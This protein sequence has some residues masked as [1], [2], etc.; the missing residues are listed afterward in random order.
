M[1]D[2]K[3]KIL[4]FGWEF[5]PVISGGLGVACLGLCKALAPLASSLKMVIPKSTPDFKLQGIDLVGLNAF[6]KDELLEMFK[7]SNPVLDVF[8]IPFEPIFPYDNVS[9]SEFIKESF[10]DTFYNDINPFDITD[11]YGGDVVRK[12]VEFAR[13]SVQYG[14]KQD[15]DVIHAHDW[16]TFL[17]AMQ[18]K[19]LTGKPMVVHIH[20]LEYDRAG[21][22]SKN[23]VWELERR[24][25]EMADAIIPVSHY[26]GFIC[27]KYYGADGAKIYPVHNG[28]E[29]IVKTVRKSPFRQKVVIF[30]GRVTMQKGPEYFV[31]AA[32][33]VLK[34][35]NNVKFVM[36]GSGDMLRPMILKTAQYNMGDKFFFTD[37]LNKKLLNDVLAISD[38]YCM[39]SVSEPFGL[40]AAE[41]AQYGIPTII[42]KTSGVAEVLNGSLKFDFWDIN[43]FAQY[44]LAALEMDGLRQEVVTKNYESLKHITWHH[45]AEKVI[46]VYKKLI[47]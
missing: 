1:T 12:V 5:P 7:G 13:I 40:S 17:P 21:E 11:L 43:K 41:A 45:A 4:M 15:F 32:R 24:A 28:I 33:L 31:E 9:D 18:L 25:M 36:A 23:W 27:Q 3:P 47:K 16:M 6:T 10:Y 34:Y 26:T 35:H 19:K 46:S 2:F 22:H 29:P 37:F 44:I 20:S 39:P 30:F 8:T 14:L 38:V 42:S